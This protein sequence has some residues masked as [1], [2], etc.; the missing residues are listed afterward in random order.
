MAEQ[1][2]EAAEKILY[3]LLESMPF[4]IPAFLRE[5][6]GENI[7]ADEV[8]RFIKLCPARYRGQVASLFYHR[9]TPSDKFRAALLACKPDDYR[10]LRRAAGDVMG[11]HAW[12]RHADLP[13]DFMLD[14]SK[15]P[16]PTFS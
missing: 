7:S 15:N 10:R 3:D 8:V 11:W 13:I 2:Q 16:P 12:L 9:G 5:I 6:I 4:P 1:D 14:G